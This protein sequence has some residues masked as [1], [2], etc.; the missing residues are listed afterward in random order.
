M[1][2]HLPVRPEYFSG[3]ARWHLLSLMRAPRTLRSI[4]EVAR[5]ADHPER[6]SI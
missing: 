3:F 1:G 2:K 4:A 5:T 6:L